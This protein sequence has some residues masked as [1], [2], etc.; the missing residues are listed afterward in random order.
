MKFNG[1]PDGKSGEKSVVAVLNLV[2]GLILWTVIE[3]K[4]KYYDKKMKLD[5]KKRM[6]LNC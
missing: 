2:S 4:N 6:I 5:D 3:L 1:S